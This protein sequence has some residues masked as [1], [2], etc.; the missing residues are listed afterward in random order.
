MVGS[1][2]SGMN[3]V[4]VLKQALVGSPSFVMN[5]QTRTMHGPVIKLLNNV[6]KQALEG[7]PSFVMNS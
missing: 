5:S 4:S 2:F 3:I 1:P 7:S 6:L